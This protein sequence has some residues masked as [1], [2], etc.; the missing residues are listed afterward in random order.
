MNQTCG[1]CRFFLLQERNIGAGICR[2]HPP[3]VLAGEWITRPSLQMGQSG[4]SMVNQVANIAG[5]NPPTTR[6]LWCGDHEEVHVPLE[7]AN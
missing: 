3:T 1:N 5:Q 4:P 7:E 2:R 6:D